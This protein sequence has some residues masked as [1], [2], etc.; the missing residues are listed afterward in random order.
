VRKFGFALFF[1][2]C[3][4]L[5]AFSQVTPTRTVPAGSKTSGPPAVADDFLIGPE[6]V[7]EFKV[8]HEPEMTTKLVVRSDGKVTVPLVGDISASGLTPDK[9]RENLE[10]KLDKFFEQP[11]VSLVILEIHSEEVHLMGAVAR[12][13]A[14]S[15]GRQLT[16]IELL[17]RAGGFTDSAKT[18]QVVINRRNSRGETER[19]V[20]NYK[21]FIEGK[22]L[23]TN[24]L[25]KSGDMII[26]PF[27]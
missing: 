26:V 5:F 24:I 22:S 16:I 11:V 8:W 6:D 14:Y 10:A 9:L 18:D 4:C 7:L 17:A 12:P 21:Q 19:I 13:G 25:L 27:N 2:H 23:N 1:I 3:V 20:F 15:L